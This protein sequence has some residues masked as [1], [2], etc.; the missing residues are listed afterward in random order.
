MFTLK[1]RQPFGLPTQALPLIATLLLLPSLQAYAQ[2]RYAGSDTAE[3]IVLAAQ[4]AYSRAHPDFKL[5][6]SAAGT[7]SGF[8]ELCGNRA[9]FVGASRPINAQEIKECSTASVKYLEIPVAIDAIAVVVSQKNTELKS[10]S[11]D[12][13]SRIY[14]PTSAGV[15][16]QWSQVRPGLSAQP[17]AVAGVNIKHGTFEVFHTAIG[18]GKFTRADYKDTADHE[19][20]IK[21]VAANPGMVGFVPMS[22]AKDFAAQVRTL[23]VDFGKGPALPQ[24]K[25][26]LDGR[27]DK[28]SRTVYFYVNPDGLAKDVEGRAFIRFALDGVENYVRFANMLPLP[29]ATY[30][31]IGKKVAF[32]Q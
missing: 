31:E 16:T 7:S 17:L 11:L 19:Q 24:L 1:I 9:S 29:K 27:Y 26:V 6:I 14:A 12:E 8:R 32:L 4:Q 13:L 2:T 5:Q 10:L 18:N 22:F 30:E 3:P 25:D 23:P 28:L 15:L 20:T 21:L